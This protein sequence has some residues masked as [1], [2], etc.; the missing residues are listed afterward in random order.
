M[1]LNIKLSLLFFLLLFFAC[2]NDEDNENPELVGSW[3]LVEQYSDP[4]DGSGDYEPVDSEFTITFNEDGTFTANSNMCNMTADT[5]GSASGKWDDASGSLEVV[6][7]A[8]AGFGITYE[9]KESYLF[10]Y[11]PCIEGCGQKFEKE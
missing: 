9:I 10:I 6:G 7:C 11:Y 1:Q 5:V 3:K 2:T 4:G 8:F